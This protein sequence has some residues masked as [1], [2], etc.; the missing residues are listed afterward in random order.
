MS[1]NID[2]IDISDMDLITEGQCTVMFPK[3]EVFYNPVQ[4]LNR[5]LSILFI[6]LFNELR[7]KEEEELRKTKPA[8]VDRIRL[9]RAQYDVD[10]GRDKVLNDDTSTWCVERDGLKILE[11]LSASGLRS[12]RYA[13]E[14]PSIKYIITNDI[15]AAAVES[16]KRNAKYNKIDIE[17]KLIPSLADATLLMYEHRNP[18]Q[19]KFDVVD[20]DPYGSANIFLDSAVQCLEDGGL[21]LVTCTDMAVLCGAQSEA[22]FSKYG[23]TSLKG[24]SYCHEYGLRVVLATLETHCNRYGKYIEPLASFSIDFYCRIFVRVHSGRAPLKL[25]PTKLSYVVQCSACDTFNLQPMGR[26]IAEGKR[27]MPA[28]LEFG[29]RCDDCGGKNMFTGPIWSSKMVDESLLDKALT[30]VKE[31]PVEE[32]PTHK[33]L[34]GLLTVL[35]EEAHE[36]PLYYNLHSMCNALHLTVPK[37][38][39][40]QGVLVNAGF[41]VS[42][43][44]CEP[45]AIK[46][47]APSRVL[48]DILRCWNKKHPNTGRRDSSGTPGA[49]ILE[50]EPILEPNWEIPGILFRE[51]PAVARY[52]QNPEKYWGPKARAV[53]KKRKAEVSKATEEDTKKTK[54]V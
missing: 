32:I 5:D 14:I 21:M 26:P 7:K 12:I 29:P 6:K 10:N 38:K 30:R 39:Q 46:T 49:R 44:H 15:E 33:R 16:I 8:K 17:K 9:A 25:T 37:L 36:I 52:P 27:A 54:T 43:S 48:W 11:A 2:D 19:K 53:G 23:S 35:S 47:N 24:Q 18:R 4:V 1:S 34:L 41:K 22:C 3:G 40:F 20:L 51:R 45:H 28:F 13:Q 31:T 50:K 42:Q